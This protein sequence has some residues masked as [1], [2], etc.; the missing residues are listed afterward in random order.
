[1]AGNLK[2][3]TKASTKDNVLEFAKKV[4]TRSS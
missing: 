2:P 1:M 4:F 3:F